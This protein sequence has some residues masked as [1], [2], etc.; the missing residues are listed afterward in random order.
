[1]PGV[2]AQAQPMIA[3]ALVASVFA[4]VFALVVLTRSDR[5]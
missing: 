3:W 4:A 2:G 1:M 5:E